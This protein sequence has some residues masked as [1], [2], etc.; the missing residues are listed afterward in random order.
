MKTSPQKTEVSKHEVEPKKPIVKESSGDKKFDA[1]I[2]LLLKKA[3]GSNPK[4]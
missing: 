2:D 3:V 4:K 1:A